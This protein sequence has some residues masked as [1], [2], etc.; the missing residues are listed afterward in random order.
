ML[1]VVKRMKAMI[2]RRAPII[3]SY[4]MSTIFSNSS[5][6]SIAHLK[7]WKSYKCWRPIYRART[8]LAENIGCPTKLS[9]HALRPRPWRKAAAYAGLTPIVAEIGFICYHSSPLRKEHCPRITLSSRG[10]RIWSAAWRRAPH[11]AIHGRRRR[12]VRRHHHQCNIADPK[13][14]PS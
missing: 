12:N 14:F 1:T 13:G 10:P 4:I 2:R 7:Q 3:I 11:A 6:R 8:A 5:S 9:G